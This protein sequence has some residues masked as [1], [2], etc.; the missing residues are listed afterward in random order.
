RWATGEVAGR[1]PHLR[2]V[3]LVV[4]ADGWAS[5]AGDGLPDDVAS[6]V[7]GLV[8]HAAPDVTGTQPSVVRTCAE[9]LAARVAPPRVEGGP[10][11]LVP[12]DIAARACDGVRILTSDG[13]AA[14]TSFLRRPMS[15]EKV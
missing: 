6:E 13:A 1:Q 7:R 10:V 11:F 8:E 12:P 15:W 5:F 4:S 14:E 2:G 9:L 3:R